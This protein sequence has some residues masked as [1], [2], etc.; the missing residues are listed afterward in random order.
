MSN[1]YAGK[2]ILITGSTGFKG[3]WLSLWLHSLGANV[4]G[5]S[6]SPYT[7]PNLFSILGLDSL[8]NQIYGDIN[9]LGKLQEICNT[10]Q[11]E[12]IFHLAAQ[13]L[14]R[15]SYRDP[16]GTFQTNV[17]GTVNI[18]EVIRN[19]ESIK[20]AVLITT[21]KVYENL[22]TMR[23]YLETDRLGGHDPYST[24][25][26]MDEL[27][28]TSYVRSFFSKGEKKIVSVRAGNV[29]G[30][31]D[32]SKDRLIPDI[33]QAFENGEPVI[34]RNPDSVRPWQH[35]LEPLSG[36]LMMGEKIFQD[37][38]Y[39]GSYNF[40]PDISD[41][42]R[43]EDIVIKAIETLGKGEYKIQKDESM[44]EAGLLLLDN[45]KA[46][47]LLGWSPKFGIDEALERTF[48]WY[49]AYADGEDMRRY[50]LQEIQTFLRQI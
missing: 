12:I 20:G 40:G 7:E 38:K 17:M 43:V 46:K 35:V 37:D 36:Y 23:P 24:S 27:A 47:K 10:Y 30:G 15:E 39:L 5:Y 25:K 41:T 44:H 3:S 16:V 49:R 11:P 29:I 9:D 19:T 34:L 26:A 1:F 45:T 13:P 4:I 18:L 2:T 28:I 42:M 8:I 21:D 31:G 22:E 33:I 14:V 48:G 50:S 6:L 32:W